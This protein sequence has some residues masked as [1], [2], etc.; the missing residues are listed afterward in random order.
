MKIVIAA[1]ASLALMVVPVS[2]ACVQSD[3]AGL[4]RIFVHFDEAGATDWDRCTFRILIDGTIKTTS[5]CIDSSGDKEFARGRITLRTNCS[6]AGSVRQGGIT[7]RIIDGQVS[8]DALSW[9]GVARQP[10]SGRL[11]TFAGI[12]R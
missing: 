3:L 1:A 5:F 4:W 7:D 2:A 6:T 9:A 8:R 10:A 11:A 12:K